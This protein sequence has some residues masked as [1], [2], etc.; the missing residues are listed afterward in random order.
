MGG[1]ASAL[2]ASGNAFIKTYV[3]LAP[4]ETNPSAASAA[5][6]INVPSLIFSGSSDGV[7]PP[8]DHHLP[9]YN[10]I[11]SDCKTFVSLVGGAHCYFANSNFN[12]DFGEGTTSTGITLTR[13]EQHDLTFDVLDPWLEYTLYEESQGLNDV[14]SISSAGDYST[15]STCTPLSVETNETETFFAYPNPTNGLIN[16]SGLLQESEFNVIDHAGRVVLLGKTNG[17]LDLSVLTEGSY[18][19]KIGQEHL[20]FVVFK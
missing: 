16:I 9:I 12:C 11:S 17:T 14:V 19:L 1:G 6:A 7:T 3:G 20:R 5:A 18:L 8:S 10:A 2:A 15:Q 4:A 13:Q